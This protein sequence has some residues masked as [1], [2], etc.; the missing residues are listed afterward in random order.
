ML[1]KEDLSVEERHKVIMILLGKGEPG[2][3]SIYMAGFKS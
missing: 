3:A 2:Y 1:G